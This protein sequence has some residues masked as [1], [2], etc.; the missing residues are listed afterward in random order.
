MLPGC[1]LQGLTLKSVGAKP[2][3][4]RWQ[5]AIPSAVD[6]HL[7]VLR[8]WQRLR[9]CQAHGEVSRVRLS[10]VK[11]VT[12]FFKIWSVAC[13]LSFRPFLFCL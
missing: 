10:R 6:E 2:R 1:T 13:L 9:K 4:N 8:A 7:A 5:F 11:F 12:A 3:A